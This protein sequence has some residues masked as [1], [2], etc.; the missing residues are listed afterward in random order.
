VFLQLQHN[1]IVPLLTVDHTA[2]LAITSPGDELNYI[3]VIQDLKNA[4]G[5]E[6]FYNI[7]I[8]LSCAQCLE[9]GK[10]DC[11]HTLKRLP[12]WKSESRHDMVR[13]VFGE[14]QEAMQ[15][16]AMGLVVS[17]RVYI[18]GKKD[19]DAFVKREPYVFQY[20]VQLIEIGIDPSGG[21][22]GSDYTIVSKCM[23]NGHDIVS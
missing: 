23:E 11:K 18:Y 19:L 21:G 16:E 12:N 8:G 4:D 9:A 5:G 6:L 7:K 3:S 22:S 10:S 15:R 14:N 20:E 17:N 2:M 1:V 13:A